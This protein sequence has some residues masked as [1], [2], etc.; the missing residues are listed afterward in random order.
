M[1]EYINKLLRSKN[2]ESNTD[3]YNAKVV[4][5]WS[6]VNTTKDQNLTLPLG[7][8]LNF[9]EKLKLFPFQIE[10]SLQKLTLHLTLRGFLTPQR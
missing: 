1:D 10:V 3:D 2:T 5:L 4:Y 9:I 7:T 6:P 8:I